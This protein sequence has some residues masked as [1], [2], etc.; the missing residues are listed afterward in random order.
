MLGLLEVLCT[1]TGTGYDAATGAPPG[2]F[3]AKA[4]IPL[5]LIG[6]FKSN[7]VAESPA[8]TAVG[9]GAGS[10]SL[11]RSFVPGGLLSLSPQYT[12]AVN[13]ID[14][15]TNTKQKAVSETLEAEAPFATKSGSVSLV[16][17]HSY[18]I[19]IE[20]ATSASV[21]GALVETAGY[22]DNVVVTG[23]NASENSNGKS[24]ENGGNGA[25]GG[26]GGDGSE[27][28]SGANGGG[29]GGGVSSARLESL[30]KS[31]SLVGPA[32]LKGNRLT[33]KA[34]C[35]AKVGTIC[36]LSL[37]GLLN[38]KKP[39]TATRRARV[40]QGKTKSF[41]LVVKPAARKVVKGRSKLLFKETVRAGKAKAT[42][43]KSLKIVRK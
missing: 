12:Y 25:G 6:L 14:K 27:G 34:K 38:R 28:G 32:T 36:T 40:K 37:Q 15:T 8:F 29:A 24:G 22:F 19:Q 4:Q 2:S 13:L 3:A 17:G 1:N 5:N 16:A 9:S 10:L 7:V 33:V 26:N 30:I 35:P 21:L 43:Y 20:A 41:A 18:A 39:A 23:P 31:S 42:V 11:A